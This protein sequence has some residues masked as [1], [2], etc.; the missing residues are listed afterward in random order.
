MK[1]ISPIVWPRT[2]GLKLVA[3]QSI[4]SFR[5]IQV[6]LTILFVAL[7]LVPLAARSVIGLLVP[8]SLKWVVDDLTAG[9]REFR[10][11]AHRKD[12]LQC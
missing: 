2:L 1:F 4:F 9:G 12:S 3:R 6:E 7:C 10:F 11:L 8:V 5:D